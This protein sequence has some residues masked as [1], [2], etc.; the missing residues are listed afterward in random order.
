MVVAFRQGLRETGYIEG[1]NVS[2]EYRWAEGLYDRL[3][4]LAADLVR[5][6][7]AVIAATGG[8][9]SGLAAKAATSSIPIVFISGSDPVNA[10]LVSNLARPE[11]NATG[12]TFFADTLM[13]KR[14]EL[15]REL[16]PDA[17]TIAVLVNPNNADTPGQL[18]EIQAAA[19]ET[20]QQLVVLNASTRS[21]I[22][23][24]FAALVQ[25]A[26]GALIVAGDPMFA[27]RREH[28]VALAAR[29]AVP[30][31]YGSRE[32]ATR[33]ALVSYGASLVDAYR[34][35]GTYT[36][37]ILRGSK[38]ADLP[39]LRSTPLVLMINLKTAKIL[40]L[41]VPTSILLLADEV[42]E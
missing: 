33:D 14:L 30:T 22:D 42:I 23:T 1:Q 38:A 4:L 11:G 15:M 9:A 20:R 21:E 41:K 2:I 5:R 34:Q 40:G 6:P 27:S 32:T 7:V 10:G 8:P 3:P 13:S 28:I 18:R 17:T 26:A 16:V 24:A 12:V 39:I 25:R 36:G 29:H 37:K 31:I 35:A 19:R